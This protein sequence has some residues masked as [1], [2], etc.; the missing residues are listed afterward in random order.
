MRLDVLVE[1]ILEFRALALVARRAHV[2]DVVGDDLD[3][4]FLGHHAGRGGVQCAH[5]S[6]LL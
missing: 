6:D 2:G 5:D 3:V 4:E 1:Q